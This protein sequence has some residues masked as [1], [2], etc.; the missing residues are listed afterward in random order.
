V[1]DI[2]KWKIIPQLKIMTKDEVVSDLL[3]LLDLVQK[4]ADK[5]GWQHCL[6]LLESVFERKNKGL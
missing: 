6:D 2:E 3:K 1:T 4:H 5:E